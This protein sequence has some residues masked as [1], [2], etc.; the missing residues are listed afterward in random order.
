MTGV[1][2][3]V[4]LVVADGANAEFRVPLKLDGL[5][6]IDRNNPVGRHIAP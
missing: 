6:R 1:A 4:P 5:W 2:T 3:A